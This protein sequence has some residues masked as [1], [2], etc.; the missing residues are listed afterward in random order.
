MRVTKY[1]GQRTYKEPVKQKKRNAKEPL[2][3]PKD[4]FV[5]YS[6][7]EIKDWKS[8]DLYYLMGVTQEEAQ[9]YTDSHY[10]DLFKRQAK[11]FHPDKLLSLQ[12]EDNGLS[13]IA[14]TKAYETLSNQHKR[15]LYDFV[16]FDEVL[17]ADREYTAEEFFDEFTEAFERNSIFS[18]KPYTV[19]L[20]TIDTKDAEIVAFYKFWQNFDSIRSFEFLCSDEDYQS[21]EM[22]RHAAQQNKQML[23]E[24][25]AEDNQR[26]RRLVSLAIKHDPRV[27]KESKK[28][29]KKDV[30]V[31]AD[32]WKS[33][34]TEALTKIASKT[35]ART[36]N[37]FELIFSAVSRHAPGKTKKEVQAKL[38]KI[39]AALQKA[40]PKKA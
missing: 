1:T 37:R 38:L 3:S 30:A 21:R 26:I 16:A 27:N 24:K 18:S 31:D 5:K 9:G 36:R 35:P 15:R 32:G 23:D 20:G 10:K 8:L 11:L 40:Q 6:L 33:T 39:D 22:R 4:L 2:K 7:E 12:I 28:K 29:E 17:P 14:L 19:K 13:F 34:E 25:K